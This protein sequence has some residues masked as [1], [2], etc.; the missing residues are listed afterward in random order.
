MDQ[1][2]FKKIFN[3]IVKL[4]S[5]QGLIN[6]KLRIIDFIHIQANV[7]LNYLTKEFKK[8]KLEKEPEKLL[9]KEINSQ[10][11]ISKTSSDFDTRFSKK[12]KN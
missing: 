8:K 5:K 3:Q 10:N 4:T 6:P 9:K 11:Y 1:E 7:N 12:S 2:R